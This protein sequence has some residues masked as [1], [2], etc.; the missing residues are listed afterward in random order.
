MINK[1]YYLLGLTCLA[2]GSCGLQA[3]DNWDGEHYSTHSNLQFQ[4]AS[5]KLEKLHLRGDENIIDIGCGDARFTEALAHH[6]SK[7]QVLGLDASDSM[8]ASANKRLQNGRVNLSFLK[9]DIQTFECEPRFDLAVSFSV[10]HWIPNHLKALQN[11]EKLLKPGGRV[12]VYFAP[13]HGYDRL[14]H[15]IDFVMAQDTWSP[16]FRDF[17]SGFC[18]IS[19]VRFA[20]YLEEAKLLLQRIEVITVDEIFPSKHAFMN[21]MSAWMTQLKSLPEEKHESFMM[22]VIDKYMETHPLDEQGQLHYYD[23]WLEAEA[24]KPS[25]VFI[26]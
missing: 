13:D 23:Y 22:A 10:F 21:W 16:Y 1:Y 4:W 5:D 12:F 11:I 8:L 20:Q 6:C 26:L 24:E 9:G 17:S 3:K 25:V 7:G 15:A 19:P 18:L 2:L 14:D